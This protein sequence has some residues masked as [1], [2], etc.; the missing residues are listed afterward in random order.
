MRASTAAAKLARTLRERN[1]EAPAQT[2]ILLAHSASKDEP[3]RCA[4]GF[5]QGLDGVADIRVQP[6]AAGVEMR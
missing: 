3:K 5:L 1:K 2:V 4:S 6:R